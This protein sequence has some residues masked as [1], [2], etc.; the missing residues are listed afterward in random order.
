MNL[1]IVKD[2]MKQ[3]QDE[4]KLSE[5]DLGE[6][7]GREKPGVEVTK[8]EGELPL[9]GKEIE[10]ELEGEE[11]E[12]DFDDEEGMFKPKSEGME[13]KKRLMALRGK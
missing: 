4:M 7:L 3:L 12:F 13:L 11:P 5:D 8:I 10:M 1:E 6:R 2:L 9:E